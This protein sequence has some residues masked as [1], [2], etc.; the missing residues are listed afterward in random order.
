MLAWRVTVGRSESYFSEH[1]DAWNYAKLFCAVSP[2]TLIDSVVILEKG[3]KDT[4]ATEFK[5]E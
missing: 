1:E 3:W 5:G 2:S 4:I